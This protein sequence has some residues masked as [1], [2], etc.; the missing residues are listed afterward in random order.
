MGINTVYYNRNDYVTRLRTRIS[1]PICWKDIL[2]V[3][4]SDIRTI[5]KAYMS[6]E[7]SVQTGTREAAY[8]N[9]GWSLTQDTLTINTFKILPMLIDEADRYQQDYVSQM[10]IADFQGD[11]INEYI[12]SQFLAQYSQTYATDF[13]AGDVDNTS[14]DD[15]TQIEVSTAEI[16]DLIRA[17]L[18][19]LYANNG[20]ELSVK[21]GVYIVWRPEDWMMLTA[22]VQAN[23]FNLADLSLKNGIPPQMAFNYMGVDHYLSTQHTTN[24]LLAGIKKCGELGILRGTFGKVKFLEDPYDATAAGTVSGLSIVSRLDYGFNFPAQLAEFT[25]DVNVQ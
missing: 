9:Q 13:G 24:H 25:M 18:R 3:T 10:S 17:I 16:D 12:E 21:N 22:F 4:Y 5:V 11:K 1:R 20:V 2:A 14:A 6:T 23:G 19:K 7:P 8:T 15:T